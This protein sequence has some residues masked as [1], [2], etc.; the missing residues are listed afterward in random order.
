MAGCPTCGTENPDR[1]K[2]CLECGAPLEAAAAPTD[3]RKLVTILFADLAGSTA[4]GERLDA[5]ALKEV[6]GGFF[7]AMREQIEAEG[8]TVEKFIGDAVMAAFGVPVAHEDDP[9]RAL[10]AAL[11][12]QRRLAALNDELGSVHGVKLGMR[13]GVNTGEVLAATAPRA[14]EAMATGDAV[15]VAARLQQAAEPG[16]VLVGDR[17]AAAVRGFGFAPAESLDLR[18]KAGGV[19]ARRLVGERDEPAR[20]VPGLRSPMVGR[21]RELELL[22]SL[23]RRAGDDRHAHLVTI[24][25]DPGVGKSRLVAEFTAQAEARV[26]RGRCLP[27]GD[28]VTFWP[29]AE[30]LKSE[31][32]VLDTDPPDVALGRITAL[33]GSAPKLTPFLAALIHTIGLDDPGSPLR[34]MAPRAVMNEIHAGWRGFF[35]ALADERPLIVVVDDIHWADAAM[36]DLL[37]ALPDRIQAP[38][39]FLCPSR[40]E[41]T[42]RRPSW[43]GGRRGASSIALEPLGPAD[44]DELVRLLLHVDGLP[45]DTHDRILER[46]EG[47]PFFLEEILRR[48]IDERLIVHESGRWRAAQGIEQV[49]LPDTIQAVLAARID[50]L[51]PAEKRAVQAAAVVGRIFWPGAVAGLLNG[52]ADQVD[53]TLDSLERRDLVLSRI[54]SAMAGERELIFKHI[55][56]RDVAYESLPRRD[57]PA[58][59][60]RVGGWIETTFGE[61]RGEVAELLA[62]HFDLAGDRPRAHRY[63]LEAAG[64]DLARLALDQ[65]RVFAT[66]AAE[67]ADDGP[68]RAAAM[69]VL[70]EIA[71]QLADGETAYRAWREAVELLAINP[72]ADRAALATVCGRLALMIARGPGLMPLTQVTPDEARRYLELGLAAAGNEESIALVELLLAEGAWAFGFPSPPPTTAERERMAAAAA[73]AVS[74]AERLDRPDLLS[75]A[76]DVEHISHELRDDVRA[77][78]VGVDRRRRLADKVV[79]FLDLDDIFYMAAQVAW[80]Q[81]RYRDAAR[82]SE[83]G[84][85]RVAALGGESKGSSST[86]AVSRC[87]LGDWDAAVVECRRVIGRDGAE[88]PGFLRP[89][90]AAAEFVL[91]ARHQT[92]ELEPLR[93]IE[94]KASMRLAFRALGLRA[95]DR[96]EEGLALV[97]SEDRPAEGRSLEMMAEGQLLE[98]LGRYAELSDL[99]TEM[100]ERAQRT[101][102][103]A[104]PAMADRLDAARLLVDD[105]PARAAEFAQSSVE[106]FA[107][108][109]AAWEAAVSGLTLAEALL[110]L[111]RADDAAAV[112]AEAEP[113]LRRAGGIAELRRFDTLAARG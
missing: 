45:D 95:E 90:C 24:Y 60:A 113:A 79:A 89:V 29:L 5:E 16:Q 88:P 9:A 81:G 103:S 39:L 96:A 110:A 46:A 66:R 8:G 52:E 7:A 104:G 23:L 15:N 31:A 55:L 30:I 49:A 108:I 105:D 82:L 36:L 65:A 18:G 21:D 20:G 48:L 85:A 58:A 112:L 4:L 11:R 19:A 14:G 54:G 102:W 1:A 6:M 69:I 56:T 42:A 99:C 3:E 38:A 34:D 25:G 26:V 91:A 33:A 50:L 35:T 62:H 98:T 72:D 74:T 68:G 44:A 84:I 17:T 47:N 111:G 92:E 71:Y 51:P 40:P 59:H 106:R 100:R 97:R 109:G 78:V 27:Y 22:S 75:L 13:I 64:R 43:G 107:A 70:G 73:R 57:R 93:Q 32:G 28:G 61:R 80:E 86:L 94:M 41:L 83:E 37:E 67:L 63:A 12:M 2:F 53:E 101:D 10:R 76:L 87:L 77:M